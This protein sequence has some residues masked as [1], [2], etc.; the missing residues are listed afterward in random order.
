MPFFLLALIFTP[1]DL[2][3]LLPSWI[4]F[5]GKESSS[6]AEEFAFD[7]LQ[8]LVNDTDV[9]LDKGDYYMLNKAFNATKLNAYAALDKDKFT[10][11][12]LNGTLRTLCDGC[13][14]MSILAVGEDR[15]INKYQ[16]QLEH[17]SC[18]AAPSNLETLTVAPVPLTERYYQ[19]TLTEFD[20]VFEAVGLSVGN[21]EVIV[22]LGMFLIMFFISMCLR[23]TVGFN[24]GLFRQ[25]D[26]QAEA[27]DAAVRAAMGKGLEMHATEQASLEKAH[28]ALTDARFVPRDKDVRYMMNTLTVVSDVPAAL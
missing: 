19:C 13:T 6:K 4:W 11:A 21:A 8:H 3:F 2:F 15:T 18:K 22:G 16:Y 25:L 27:N 24:D 14:M 12:Q 23:T 17:G 28:R 20:A 7:A 9:G 10:V 1:V 26:E 5:P